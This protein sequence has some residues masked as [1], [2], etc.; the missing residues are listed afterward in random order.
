MSL[1]IE[2]KYLLSGLPDT[3]PDKVLAITQLYT[4]DGRYRSVVDM[5][6]YTIDYV[7]TKKT[8]V[9]PGIH[10]E[11]ERYIGVFEYFSQIP[12]VVCGLEK[13]RY[14]FSENRLKYEVDYYPHIHLYTLEVELKSMDQYFEMPI[15]LEKYVVREITGEENY[16]NYHLAIK[17]ISELQ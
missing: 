8:P 2:R 10:E 15:W 16:S 9:A 4:K 17:T 6:S 11:D 7:E 14:V 5:H 13:I 12:N 3:T 1:E